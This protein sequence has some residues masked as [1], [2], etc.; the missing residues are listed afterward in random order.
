MIWS[1]CSTREETTGFAAVVDINT[2][3]V[4]L[5]AIDKK[6]SQLQRNKVGNHCCRGQQPAHKQA[7]QQVN[8]SGNQNTGASHP[9]QL[10]RGQ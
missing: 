5:L 9:L 3:D 1:H 8:L 7:M 10:L 2:L 4:D 6:S